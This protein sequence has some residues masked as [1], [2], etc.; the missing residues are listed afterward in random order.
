MNN[1][2]RQA[3]RAGPRLADPPAGLIGSLP[4][5]GP[6]LGS[7]YRR[8]DILAHLSLQRWE[9]VM[10]QFSYR[11]TIG[12]VRREIGSRKAA[13]VIRVMRLT[14]LSL[15]LSRERGGRR[16]FLGNG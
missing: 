13:N 4:A 5:D 1:A 15:H 14:G 6:H 7:A 10:S 9:A 12:A 11:P 16:R 8:S 3:P 2:T